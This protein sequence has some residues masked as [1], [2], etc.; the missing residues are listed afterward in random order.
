MHRASFSPG[1]AS[2]PPPDEVT[3]QLAEMH[4][5]LAALAD[6]G[7]END[8]SFLQSLVVEREDAMICDQC[9]ERMRW[10]K[11]FPDDYEDQ[12]FTCDKCY[13]VGDQARWFCKKCSK[14]VCGDCR[15]PPPGHVLAPEVNEFEVGVQ[16]AVTFN[17]CETEDASGRSS[18]VGGS[19][20]CR[21]WTCFCGCRNVGEDVRC[22]TCL[23]RLIKGNL[24]NTVPAV[25]VSAVQQESD[26]EGQVL[27]NAA[28]AFWKPG[29]RGRVK[30]RG[31]T[32]VKEEA[33]GYCAGVAS[34]TDCSDVVQE[35]HL[36]AT[37]VQD[38]DDDF[39]MLM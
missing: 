39:V 14:D 35:S 29:A 19:R 32:R 26:D 1:W 2:F 30:N 12:K 33:G 38:R 10:T 24:E 20:A 7:H 8:G 18:D 25:S 23:R 11:K 37:V 34:L 31:R 17:R 22:R 28:S 13:D 5:A 9:W 36:Q 3:A 16:A 6:D 4:V 21:T 27:K 15:K